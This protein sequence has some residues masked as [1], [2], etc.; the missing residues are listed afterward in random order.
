MLG[1]RIKKIREIQNLGLNETA[2]LAGIS[3]SYLS[4]IEKGIKTNP[5]MEALN[6]IADALGVSVDEFFKENEFVVKESA[7]EYDTNLSE[8][9]PLKSDDF[10]NIP[11]VGVVR[12]GQPI[13]AVENIE[14]YI[15]LPK[16]IVSSDK[17]YYGLRVQGDSMNL[18]FKEG[19]I[20]I[21]EK[22]SCID[23]GEIGVVTVN[24]YEATVKKIVQNE[25]MITLIP[26]SNNPE[27]TPK[28]YDIIKDEVRI[29]GKVKCSMKI[30]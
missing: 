27:H 19:T 17:E 25:N 23:N 24:G 8:A 28:M 29:A 7:P 13:L 6:K 5:S 15:P 10:I 2:K 11:I 3:G 4:N 1:N 16:S 21:V 12:A 22:T 30:Y 9:F 18:E 14:G 26:M 20:L